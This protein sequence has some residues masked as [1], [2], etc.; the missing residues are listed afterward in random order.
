MIFDAQ[1]LFSE[2][3]AITATAVSTN[4][5][6]LGIARKGEGEPLAQTINVTEAFNLLTDL[7]VQLQT[8]DNAAFASA[9]VAATSPAVPLASLVKGYDF[10]QLTVLPE[11]LERYVRLNYVK[12]GAGVPTTGKITAAIATGRQTNK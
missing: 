8:D 9:T 10:P 12:G 2:N 3:Q 5:I 6:D 11:K 4:V 1:N 7:T